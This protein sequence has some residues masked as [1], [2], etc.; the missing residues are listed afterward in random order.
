[1]FK[2]IEKMPD[3][4]IALLKPINPRIAWI[5][6]HEVHLVLV[7]ERGGN[8]HV[9]FFT[10]DK[11]KRSQLT[12]NRSNFS[13]ALGDVTSN[14]LFL[15]AFA[16]IALLQRESG[17][18][19]KTTPM[20]TVNQLTAEYLRKSL[21]AIDP[22]R[23]VIV[24]VEPFAGVIMF[25]MDGLVFARGEA[26]VDYGNLEFVLSLADGRRVLETTIG[27]GG[28]MNHEVK[29]VMYKLETMAPRS[30]EGER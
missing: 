22:A 30:F 25:E 29:K 12:Y 10:E 17:V 5:N 28:S 3:A 8:V 2:I 1:M 15:T 21:D 6:G 26:K 9:Q 7:E 24:T 4:K 14:D 19:G 11:N 20:F 13:A 27:S 16:R 18:G 23:D